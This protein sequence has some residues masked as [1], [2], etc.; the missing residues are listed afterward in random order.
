MNAGICLLNIN[1][2]IYFE[3]QHKAYDGAENNAAYCCQI[4]YTENHLNATDAILLK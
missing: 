4:M 3:V 1:I 2:I